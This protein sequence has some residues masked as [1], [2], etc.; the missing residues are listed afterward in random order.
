MTKETREPAREPQEWLPIAS[1][2][3]DGTTVLL[4]QP[5]GAWKSNRRGIVI[6]TGYW[7][8]PANPQSPGFWCG[9]GAMVV[10]RP[11]H[12]R[13]LPPPPSSPISETPSTAPE[14][15]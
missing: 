10:V 6:G 11:T 5:L 3:T 9:G 15:P 4:Y 14:E 7:H 8:Q 12:W 13:P 1:A 2:P